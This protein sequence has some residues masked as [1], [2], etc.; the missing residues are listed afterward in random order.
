MGALPVR[1]AVAGGEETT[2]SKQLLPSVPGSRTEVGTECILQ[3]PPDRTGA[4][5][6]DKR[7][8]GNDQERGCTVPKPG[9]AI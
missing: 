5:K 9:V 8:P 6:A 2:A 7:D 3:M 1:D 4:M